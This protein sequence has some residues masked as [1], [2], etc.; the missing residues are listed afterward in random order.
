[1]TRIFHLYSCL[2]VKEN[3][4]ALSVALLLMRIYCKKESCASFKTELLEMHAY[5]IIKVE[6]YVFGDA[7]FMLC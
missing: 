5:A 7:R 2:V 3:G 4:M 1:M 6:V